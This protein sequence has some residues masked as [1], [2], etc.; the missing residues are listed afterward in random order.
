MLSLHGYP[1]ILQAPAL[2]STAAVIWGRQGLRGAVK[3]L[4]IGGASSNVDVPSN[5]HCPEHVQYQ[6]ANC[7]AV[8]QAGQ[9]GSSD[10]S[11]CCAS[12][13]RATHTR[14]QS[15]RLPPWLQLSLA[16]L[17]AQSD[18]PG[19]ATRSFSAAGC[20]AAAPRR[21]AYHTSYIAMLPTSKAVESSQRAACCPPASGEALPQVVS[22]LRRQ[23][24]SLGVAAPS[25]AKLDAIM[26]LSEVAEL[27]GDAVF[28][29]WQQCGPQLRMALELSTVCAISEYAV[30]CLDDVNSKQLT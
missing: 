11:L 20:D 10:G 16:V 24:S 15:R 3:P 12:S 23:S 22:P 21:C 17:S 2:V 28:S 5:A 30:S 29:L 19:S 7:A 18:Q 27:D 14:V 9:L 6:P 4:S 25:P 8:K 26:K 13:R 1:R